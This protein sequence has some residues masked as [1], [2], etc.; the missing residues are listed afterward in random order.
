MVTRPRTASGPQP[1]PPDGTA[2]DAGLAAFLAS[3]PRSR[4]Q[5]DLARRVLPAGVAKGASFQPPYPLYLD[6]G[7]GCYV[8]TVDGQRLLDVRGHHT[9]TILGHG[10]PA[11][12]AAVRGQLDRGAALGG[13]VAA[14]YG[15]AA[16]LCR[17]VPA[18]ERVRFTSSGTEAA[19]HALR[20]VRGRTGRPKVAKFE[21]AYHGSVDALD[22]SL[23]PPAG[24]AGPADAPVA[25]PNVRGLARGAVDDVLVLPY[26]RPA[27]VAG[28]LERHRSELAAVFFDP[29]AGVLPI[30][31]D[32]VRFLRRVTADL[33]LLLV[34]DEVVSFRLGPGGLQGLAGVRPDLTLFGKIIGGG[35]PLGAL[36]GRA[37]L[38]GLLDESDGP[39]GFAQSGTFSGHPV[40]LAAGLATLQALTPEAF[41]HLARLGA[42]VRRGCDE[43]FARAGVA[44]RA[45]GDGSLFSLHFTDQAVT[46]ARTLQ[47]ADGALARRVSFGLIAGGVLPAPGLTMNALSVPMG[48]AQVRA[49]L[50]ALDD[51][52]AGATQTGG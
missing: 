46:D 49:L 41:A 14:E 5:F 23:R 28:L 12:A 3:T 33:G 18:V 32:F 8:T 35:F 26:N 11:V 20:L 37:D 2:P 10:H 51:A 52:L 29:R 25:V 43:R 15:L 36:G 13:P 4:A 16:E 19:L 21:G 48:D 42:A 50:D 38:L 22:V 7:E 45:V 9:A 17:R 47:T 6:R 24:G 44:A 30:D 40:A 39:S 34:L 27:A 1:A 31:L